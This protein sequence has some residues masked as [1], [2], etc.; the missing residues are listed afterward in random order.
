MAMDDAATVIRC[1]GEAAAVEEEEEVEGDL[2]TPLDRSSIS[3]SSSRSDS[4]D[5]VP[6]PIEVVHAVCMIARDAVSGSSSSGD[7]GGGA[8]GRRSLR[9]L[10]LLLLGA[11]APLDGPLTS[12]PYFLLY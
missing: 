6:L 4:R 7:E 2:A 5:V 11:V 12:T 9:L 8:D 1:I 3:A 10:L